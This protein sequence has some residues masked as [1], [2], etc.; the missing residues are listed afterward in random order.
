MIKGLLN[1][2][3]SQRHNFQCATRALTW[4]VIYVVS[5]RFTSKAPQI[6]SPIWAC[7]KAILEQKICAAGG[8]D[9]LIQNSTSRSK[10]GWNNNICLTLQLWLIFRTLDLS[11]KYTRSRFDLQIFRYFPSKVWC[12]LPSILFPTKGA[13]LIGSVFIVWEHYKC[14]IQNSLCKLVYHTSDPHGLIHLLQLIAIKCSIRML[15]N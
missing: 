6:W 13:A 11:L 3:Y 14:L 8:T 10:W 15:L 2:H 12:E 5:W 7:G 4:A 1:R 9:A